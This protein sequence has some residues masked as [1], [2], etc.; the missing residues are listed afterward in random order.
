MG[1]H[2]NG[3]T[4]RSYSKILAAVLVA[5]LAAVG[6]LT[7]IGDSDLSDAETSGQCGDNL[8]WT[9][10]TGTKAL[11]ITGSGA[12]YDYEISDKHW[13]GMWNSDIHSVSL[14]SGLTYIG[15]YAFE[16][17]THMYTVIIPDT[18]TSIGDGAFMCCALT[19]L[20]VPTSV[21]HIGEYA[22]SNNAFTALVLPES[23]TTIEG[24]SFGWCVNLTSLTLPKS[25]THIKTDAFTNS[26]LTSVK[27][28]RNCTVEDG[29]FDANVMIYYALGTTQN[30]GLDDT[31]YD[32]AEYTMVGVVCLISILLLIPAMIR[33]PS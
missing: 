12:M 3:G 23:L 21:T 11:T 27:V 9:Y 26:L 17:A 8:H 25:V 14:P 15:K 19:T 29:A 32:V 2:L 13:G 10:D 7:V 5:A 31:T 30:S 20:E 28:A 18:V 1:N 16:S 24:N 4:D 22:F 6:F 33:R